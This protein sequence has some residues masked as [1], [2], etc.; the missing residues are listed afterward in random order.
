MSYIYITLPFN[1]RVCLYFLYGKR[2]YKKDKR[3]GN[4]PAT[5]MAVYNLFLL[6]NLK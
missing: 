5:S 6:R 1:D 4:G 2:T 3:D